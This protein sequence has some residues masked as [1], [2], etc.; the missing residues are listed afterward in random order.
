MWGVESRTRASG[1]LGREPV[2]MGVVV[3]LEGAGER[4]ED[5]G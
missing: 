2:A 4:D 1:G 3:V 5:G